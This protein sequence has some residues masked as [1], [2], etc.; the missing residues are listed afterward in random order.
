MVYIGVDADMLDW[1][2]MGIEYAVQRFWQNV[3]NTVEHLYLCIFLNVLEKPLAMN[4]G[5]L[6]TDY[7]IYLLRFHWFTVLPGKKGDVTMNDL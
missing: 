6:Y 1:P 5:S 2:S 3:K 4:L 7:I